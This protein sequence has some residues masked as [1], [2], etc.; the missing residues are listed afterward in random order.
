MALYEETCVQWHSKTLAELRDTVGFMLAAA[1]GE[2]D[3]GDV[4]RLEIA[5]GFLSAWE[6][7][8]APDQDA[9]DA[10]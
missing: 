5:E 2:E 4:V 10:K 7:F 8:R 1:V 3:E 6:R 9:I